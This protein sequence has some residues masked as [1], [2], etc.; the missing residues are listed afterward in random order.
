MVTQGADTCNCFRCVV[1]TLC[2]LC[3]FARRL[4]A[5]AIQSKPMCVVQLMHGPTL[6]DFCAVRV[7]LCSD[8]LRSHIIYNLILPHTCFMSGS[9]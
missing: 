3:R 9:L 6:T 1:V 2:A 5:I 4:Q 8:A 7:L